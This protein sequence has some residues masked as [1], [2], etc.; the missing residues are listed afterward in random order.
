MHE[1]VYI[2]FKQKS[3]VRCILFKGKS[4]G[5]IPKAILGLLEFRKKGAIMHPDP[6]FEIIC[7]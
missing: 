2:G 4:L 1:G 3:C 5:E 6:L 7:V